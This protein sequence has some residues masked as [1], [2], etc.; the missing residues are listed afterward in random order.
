MKAGLYMN[1]NS[2]HIMNEAWYWLINRNKKLSNRK[3][4]EKISEKKNSS[5]L[6][7]LILFYL[8]F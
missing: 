2:H 7:Y 5:W 6:I 3:K 8:S 1:G 4:S